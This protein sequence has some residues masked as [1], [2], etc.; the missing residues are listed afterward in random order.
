MTETAKAS[1][2]QP[3]KGAFGRLLRDPRFRRLWTA[4]LVS[5]IGDWLVIGLLIPMVS[6]LSGGSSFAVAGILIAK[7]IPALVLSGVTGA[8]VDRF[9]RRKTM[10]VADV[11]RALLVLVLLSTN[12]L[13]AIYAIVLLMET[14]SLFFWPARNALIPYLVEEGDVTVANGVMYTTQQASMLI[15]LTASGAIL[16][17]FEAVVRTVIAADM[18][19]V[20][21]LVGLASPALL[22]PRAGFFLDFMT[23]SISALI[24]SSI[25]VDARPP[26][27]KEAFRLS[28][29]GRDVRES[30]TF[31]RDHRELKGLLVTLFFAILGGG[32]I[33]PVGLDYVKTLVSGPVFAE[34]LAWLQQLSGS[35][36]T[37]MLV[38]MAAGMV[39]GALIVPRLERALS[40][41]VLFAGSVAGFGLAML[42]FASVPVYGLAGLF[43]MGAGA[44]IATLTVA[45][46]SYVVQT[47]SD[48]IRG[49]VFTALESVV[50]VAL[51]LSMVVMAPLNDIIGGYVLA[52]VEANGLAP[53]MLALTGPRITLMLSATIVLGAAVYGFTALRWQECDDE[54]EPCEEVAT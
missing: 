36:Q 27:S 19:V 41:Q 39:V 18:P 49:R 54:G 33:I 53:D 35:P 31:L 7:I 43:A 46:N 26:G 34:G 32:A 14:A 3:G 29:L 12:S 24:I 28:L 51:L 2:G 23:F 4:Q 37:F 11:V 47:T 6:A 5:G 48:E 45:G 44:C 13:F 10:I 25:R 20:D 30:Y 40:L 15:G 17:G 16:A 50:R 21:Y 1:A 8:L 52:F 9:D 38:F 22:G 42:G